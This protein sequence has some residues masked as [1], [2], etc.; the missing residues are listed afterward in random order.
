MRICKTHLVAGKLCITFRS[1]DC[2]FGFETHCKPYTA[3]S[4]R[5]MAACARAWWAENA[6]IASRIG[7]E[8]RER[9]ALARRCAETNG[10]SGRL[11]VDCGGPTCL[12]TSSDSG[13]VC[14][15][16]V[17]QDTHWRYAQT[18][19]YKAATSWPL[20]SGERYRNDAT[21]YTERK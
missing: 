14:R 4:P 12:W 5:R 13:V 21:R 2:R 10:A 6:C 1:T 17:K 11:D 8:R 19:Q 16:D 3:S 15:W 18:S 9:G 7:K 20:R